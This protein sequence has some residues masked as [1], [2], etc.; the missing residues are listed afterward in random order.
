MDYG[1]HWAGDDGDTAPRLS[2][3]SNASNPSR[4]FQRVGAFTRLPALVRS[5]GR[6]PARLLARAGLANDA[7]DDPDARIPYDG[8]ARL[9]AACAEATGQPR[10]ALLAGGTWRLDDLG[11]VGD[12]VRNSATVGEALDALT[13]Y[14]HLD[15]RGGTSFV[16]RY[17]TV[18]DVGY[19]VYEP[20]LDAADH[21][22]DAALAG[23][24]S[25]LRELAGAAFE[26]L[27]VFVPHARP[28][29]VDDYR[30]LFRRIPHFDADV[31]ALRFPRFWLERPVQGA[32]PERRRAA[33]ARIA[34][35]EPPDMRDSVARAFRK[36]LLGGSASG[37]DL[38]AMLSIH[39]R[40]LNR[41]LR[42]QGTTFQKMLDETRFELARQLLVYSRASLDD[43]AVALG[44]SAVTPF[45]RAFHR[46][47]GMTPGQWRRSES[48]AA[49]IESA[50]MDVACSC[51]GEC[52]DRCDQTAFTMPRRWERP[53]TP[54][55]CV[56]ES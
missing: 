9:L 50:R 1:F 35:E 20:G 17:D 21:L 49:R 43:V 3:P 27:A 10:F 8:C 36:L 2:A 19:A 4:A 23:L 6:D 13:A 28:H 18:V 31:C 26:P 48:I 45:M 39:R 22:Y 29:D 30:A 55:V 14:Q 38:A 40:T 34:L 16:T 24:I 46:W 12:A 42:E 7:L 51:R 44:Y 47:T 37:D 41:R 32:D 33:V 53:R 56:N 11:V 5:F 54:A 15:R 52:S 25:I